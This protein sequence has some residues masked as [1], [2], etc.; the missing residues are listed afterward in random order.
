[1]GTFGPDLLVSLSVNKYA[2]VLTEL[3]GEVEELFA[4]RHEYPIWPAHG[5]NPSDS[6]EQDYHGYIRH[7]YYRV[8]LSMVRM[9]RRLRNLS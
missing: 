6:Y 4:C 8:V 7:N 9:L 3:E 2:Q 5:E 1:M